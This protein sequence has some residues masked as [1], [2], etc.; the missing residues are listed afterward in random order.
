MGGGTKASEVQAA[1]RSL[2][3]EGDAAAAAAAEA[4]VDDELAEFTNE[5]ERATE[6]QRE[7]SHA[8]TPSRWASAH[9]PHMKSQKGVTSICFARRP[10]SLAG[11]LSHAAAL[12][13]SCCTYQAHARRAGSAEAEPAAPAAADVDASMHEVAAMADATPIG[14]DVL[15]HIQSRL[16][17]VE[18]YAV[19]FLEEVRPANS[20]GMCN[21]QL[22]SAEPCNVCS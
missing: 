6:D 13:P 17:P 18:L 22:C 3:D 12:L 5:P 10:H 21:A 11:S 15:A 1:M 4:E 9:R 16:R 7:G 14:T 19:R 8:D 20:V 2:E